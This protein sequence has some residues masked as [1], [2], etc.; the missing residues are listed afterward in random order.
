MVPLQ[1]QQRGS[2]YGRGSRRRAGSGSCSCRR[3]G[4][5]HPSVLGTI[6]VVV[7]TVCALAAT[8]LRL[9]TPPLLYATYRLRALGPVRILQWPDLKGPQTGVTIQPG[10]LINVDE[11]DSFET[12]G[13]NYWRLTDQEGWVG[14]LGTDGI[15]S[16]KPIVEKVKVDIK[17][18]LEAATPMVKAKGAKLRLSPE[19]VARLETSN[20]RTKDAVEHE[21][22]KRSSPKPTAAGQRKAVSSVRRLMQ[23]LS[24]ATTPLEFDSLHQQLKECL[25]KQSL[26]LGPKLQRLTHEVQQ[27]LQLHERRIDIMREAQDASPAKATG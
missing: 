27:L 18:E 10:R 20:T 25:D 11:S 23:R 12:V 14:E 15:W 5:R 8:C 2:F 3:S 13:I 26:Q 16:G 17:K 4:S 22:S 1:P 9:P 6:I 21:K 24:E 7:G 19:A